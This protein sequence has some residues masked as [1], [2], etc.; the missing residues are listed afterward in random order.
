M[1]FDAGVEDAPAVDFEGMEVSAIKSLIVEY[2]KQ[3]RS[4]EKDKKEYM[5]GSNDAVKEIKSRIT[6]ALHE[7][8]SKEL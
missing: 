6:S 4:L 7:L 2:V 1:S 3:I 5:A 8:S